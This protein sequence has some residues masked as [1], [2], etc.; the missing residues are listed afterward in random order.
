MALIEEL[1]ASNLSDYALSAYTLPLLPLAARE[2]LCR[3]QWTI[4][5]TKDFVPSP[6]RPV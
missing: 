5:G 6:F 1:T 4:E 3:L 2:L